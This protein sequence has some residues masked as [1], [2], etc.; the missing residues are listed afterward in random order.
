MRKKLEIVLNAQKIQFTG[1]GVTIKSYPSGVYRIPY[2]KMTYAYLRACDRESG[3]Y[4][5]PELAEISKDLDGEFV[6]YDSDRRQ[7]RIRTKQSGKT[8]GF[9]LTE[10]AMHAPYILL[11]KQ[12]WFDEEDEG[13]FMEIESMVHLRHQC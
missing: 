6:I 12:Q 10:L 13:A 11:G 2:K 3:R 8:A 5:E 7:Y 9:L 4:W 1:S